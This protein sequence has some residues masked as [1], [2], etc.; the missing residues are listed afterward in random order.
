[1]LVKKFIDDVTVQ[2]LFNWTNNQK[3]KQTTTNGNFS[4]LTY[5]QNLNTYPKC[6]NEIR[7]KC[8]KII[9]GIY[10]EPIHKD[11]ILEIFENGYVNE[12]TDLTTGNYKHL[13][14]NILLQKPEKG[15][16]L[17]IDKQIIDLD[18]GD[19]YVVDTSILHAVSKVEGIKDY[20]S[21]VFGFLCKEQ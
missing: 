14:C 11:F 20:K 12:H 8:R 17:T 3:L 4:S 6:L 7:E 9:N 16:K 15:G 1:M 18:V 5:L 2:E 19:M 13:R 21:I 10:Q